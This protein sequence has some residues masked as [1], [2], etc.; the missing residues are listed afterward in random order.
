MALTLSLNE[1]LQSL[2]ALSEE[3]RAIVQQ[4]LER[5]SSRLSSQSLS[6]LL[7]AWDDSITLE[8][9]EELNRLMHAARLSKTEPPCL[10]LPE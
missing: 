5:E 3:E 6:A 8:D 7:E 1:I 2:D 4:Y 10:E 9:A